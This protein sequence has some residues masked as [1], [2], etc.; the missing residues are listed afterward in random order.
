MVGIAEQTV[1]S[2]LAAVAVASVPLW[3]GLFATLRGQRSCRLAWV[4]LGIGFLGVLWLNAGSSLTASP[5][6]L[7]ALLLPPVPW[8]FGSFWTK[9]SDLL[10]P[11]MRGAGEVLCGGPPVV[12][13]KSVEEG[14]GV[15]GTVLFGGV[16]IF[17]T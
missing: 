3:I 14:K 12:D 13:R 1:S 9:G 5:T 4:G 2:G 15:S 10:S 17:N 8:A 16:S 6:A 11:F 7:V